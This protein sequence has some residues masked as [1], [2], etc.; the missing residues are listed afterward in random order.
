[1]SKESLKKLNESLIQHFKENGVENAY[2]YEP[3]FDHYWQQKDKIGI[4]N[5]ESYD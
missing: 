3:L 2:Y 4:C 5:L 1:M